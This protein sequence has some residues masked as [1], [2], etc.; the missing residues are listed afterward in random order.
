MRKHRGTPSRRDK[1]VTLAADSPPVGAWGPSVVGDQSGLVGYKSPPL[2]KREAPSC[3]SQRQRQQ[4]PWGASPRQSSPTYLLRDSGAQGPGAEPMAV[5]CWHP[6]Q[7]WFLVGV[8]RQERARATGL[9]CGDAYSR[10]LTRSRLRSPGGSGVQISLLLL[11]DPL[12][13]GSV[14]VFCCVRGCGRRREWR[15]IVSPTGGIPMHA[16]LSQCWPVCVWSSFRLV[17]VSAADLIGGWLCYPP[18]GRLLRRWVY[19][20]AGGAGAAEC[21]PCCRLSCFWGLLQPACR[22]WCSLCCNRGV[23]SAL[24]WFAVGVA[25]NGWLVRGC[26]AVSMGMAGRDRLL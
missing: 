4:E 12:H 9:A 21:C 23:P 18:Y 11:V 22:M 14:V 6:H 3:S 26:A 5:P 15:T 8:R 19:R 2:F 10:L 24:C 25:A 20:A 16:Q 13:N 1:Y 7:G 17:V